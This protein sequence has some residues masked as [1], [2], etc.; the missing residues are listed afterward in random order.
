MQIPHSYPSFTWGL[1]SG[2]FPSLMLGTSYIQLRQSF[3]F[4]NLSKTRWTCLSSST[5]DIHAYLVALSIMTF[6]THSFTLA[7]RHGFDAIV[8][9]DAA[10]SQG[11]GRLQR[12]PTSFKTNTCLEAQKLIYDEDRGKRYVKPK[13]RVSPQWLISIPW[14]MRMV[15]GLL[16]PHTHKMQQTFSTWATNFDY[17]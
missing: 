1:S 12:M 4:P 3:E 16:S 2:L 13:S 7:N 15:C 5:D 9:L 10:R 17:V 11:Q 8:N 14:A 6:D